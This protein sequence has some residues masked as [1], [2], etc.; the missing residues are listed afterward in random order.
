MKKRTKLKHK[1]KT[2]SKKTEFKIQ[3]RE[4]IQEAYPMEDSLVSLSQLEE[5]TPVFDDYTGEV[6]TEEFPDEQAIGIL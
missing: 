1:P 6:V 2:S 4:A 3:A 5:T